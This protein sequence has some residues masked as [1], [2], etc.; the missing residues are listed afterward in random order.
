MISAFMSSNKLHVMGSQINAFCVTSRNDF[1]P[2]VI[3]D[4]FPD[5][6]DSII[7]NLAGL[8]GSLKAEM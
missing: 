6:L 8:E 3:L 2:I 1:L 7:E 4:L 5:W